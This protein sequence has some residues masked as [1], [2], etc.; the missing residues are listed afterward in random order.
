MAALRTLSTQD[1]RRL[2]IT[3]QHLTRKPKPDLL[4][5]IRDLGCVQLDPI[6]AVERTH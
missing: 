6:R 2:A 4:G 1:V 3:R 5:V